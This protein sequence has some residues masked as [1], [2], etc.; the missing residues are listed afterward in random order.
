MD[1][2]KIYKTD[3]YTEEEQKK[4]EKRNK[5][6]TTNEIQINFKIEARKL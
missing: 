6:I 3:R 2:N 5:T 4:S 1:D